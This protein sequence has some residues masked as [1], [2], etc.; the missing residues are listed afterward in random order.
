MATSDGIIFDLVNIVPYLKKFHRHPVTGK[1]L[2]ASDLIKL[3]FNKNAEGQ[4]SCPVLFKTFNQHTHIVAI[5]TTGNVFCY[6]AVKQL[7]LK[8]GNLQDL[9]DGTP[10]ERSDVITIQ[11]PSNGSVRE[12]EHF[13]HVAEISHAGE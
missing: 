4:Y 9:V 11:D 12:M 13:S 2:A 8:A 10:F 7:N 5:R 6:E 3:H 1:P